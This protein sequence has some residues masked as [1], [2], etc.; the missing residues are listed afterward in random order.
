MKLFFIDGILWMMEVNGKG[1]KRGGVSKSQKNLNLDFYQRK[2]SEV[3]IFNELK[4]KD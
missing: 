2:G 1:R 3:L 4:T